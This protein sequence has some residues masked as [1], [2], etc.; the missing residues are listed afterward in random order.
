MVPAATRPRPCT[1]T[2]GGVRGIGTPSF[3]TSEARVASVT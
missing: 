2:L 3:V 1:A